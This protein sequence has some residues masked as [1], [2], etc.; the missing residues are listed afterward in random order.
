M[1]GIALVIAPVT[2]RNRVVTGEFILVNAAGA[3]IL[4]MGNGPQANGSWSMPP[5]PGIRIDDPYS[6]VNSFWQYAE[7]L[8]TIILL[9]LLHM[10][11]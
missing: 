8:A 7:Q 3:A 4:Y 6:L 5:F 1:L 9:V 10:C 11:L 2:I